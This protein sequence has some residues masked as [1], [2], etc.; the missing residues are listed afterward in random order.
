M[1]G[2]KPGNVWALGSEELRSPQVEKEQ[3]RMLS[4]STLEKA[5][6]LEPTGWVDELRC[7]LDKL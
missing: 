3:P 4:G 5:A 1:D 7:H 2:L 6:E